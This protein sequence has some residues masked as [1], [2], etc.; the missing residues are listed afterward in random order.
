M[1]NR[2]VLLTD[3][4]STQTP[5]WCGGLRAAPSWE[6]LLRIRSGLDTNLGILWLFNCLL[7]FSAHAKYLESFRSGVL[8]LV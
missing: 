7:H 4:P 5:D 3:L 2:E 8:G 1:K 6:K